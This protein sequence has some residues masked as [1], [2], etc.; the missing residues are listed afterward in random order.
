MKVPLLPHHTKHSLDQYDPSEL[1]TDRSHDLPQREICWTKVDPQELTPPPGI[2]DHSHNL[3]ER[4]DAV[5]E[6]IDVLKYAQ[7]TLVSDN[8]ELDLT[9]SLCIETMHSQHDQI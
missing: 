8:N 5:I 3:L 1:L 7:T 6:P 9:R 4:K 2:K